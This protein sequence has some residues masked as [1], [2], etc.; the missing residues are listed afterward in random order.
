MTNM[1][2]IDAQH[3]IKTQIAK[4][5]GISKAAVSRWDKVPANRVLAVSRIT[6]IPCHILRPDLHEAPKEIANEI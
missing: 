2:L 6:G 3:G 1:T 5:L 4:E